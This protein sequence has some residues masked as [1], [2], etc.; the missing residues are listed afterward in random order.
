MTNTK[1]AYKCIKDV[2]KKISNWDERSNFTLNGVRNL[3]RADMDVIRLYAET[4]LT[5]G[6][7]HGL[8]KPLGSIKNVLDSYQ[9]V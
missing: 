2:D 1:N 3:S 8:M 7:Y 5:Y 6:S 4:Y 9:L